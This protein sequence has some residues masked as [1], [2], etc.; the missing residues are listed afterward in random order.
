MAEETTTQ[1]FPHLLKEESE[2]WQ[3]FINILG[4][5]YDY[6]SYDVRV[7]K[8]APFGKEK[9][10][11]YKK[12][13]SDLTQKR[14]DAIGFSVAGITIFEIRPRADLPILG[15]LLGYKELLIK[16]FHPTEQIFLAV[17]SDRVDDDDAAV[18][19]T[20]GIQIFIV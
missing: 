10:E 2:I 20:H 15:K 9:D 11:K 19:S 5:A 12:M 13:W 8:G 16:S 17:V 7:G 4:G 1:K 14:I 3:R 18:F 6:F